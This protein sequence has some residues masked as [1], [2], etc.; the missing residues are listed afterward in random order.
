MQLSIIIF[1]YLVTTFATLR[2]DKVTAACSMTIILLARIA[3]GIKIPLKG[4]WAALVTSIRVAHPAVVVSA[5]VIHIRRAEVLLIV[6]HFTKNLPI[7]V[8]DLLGTLGAMAV[9]SVRATKNATVLMFVPT[10]IPVV[11]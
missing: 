11:C 10:T 5:A 9:A 8:S 6:P 4:P 2:P 3:W 7:V 1:L